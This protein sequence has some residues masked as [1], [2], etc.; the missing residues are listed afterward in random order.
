M[1]PLL[2]EFNKMVR[3]RSPSEKFFLGKDLH[4]GDLSFG[5]GHL[6][7][8]HNVKPSF[9]G[10]MP[11]YDGKKTAKCELSLQERGGTMKINSINCHITPDGNFLLGAGRRGKCIKVFDT[12]LQ[13]GWDFNLL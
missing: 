13:A 12:R 9:A 4:G 1:R 7:P 5:C 6:A 11:E 3:L 10:S 2:A 8:F